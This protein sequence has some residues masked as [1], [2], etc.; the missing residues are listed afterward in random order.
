MWNRL[1]SLTYIFERFLINATHEKI[2]KTL[3]RGRNKYGE[4][5]TLAA[6]ITKVV[7]A[8]IAAITK[9]N[10]RRPGSI[11]PDMMTDEEKR[12][13]SEGQAF[14]AEEAAFK[15]LTADQRLRVLDDRQNTVLCPNCKSKLHKSD[16]KRDKTKTLPH[17]CWEFATICEDC[18]VRVTYRA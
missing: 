15:K 4:D 11:K 18:G 8:G 2:K 3:R 1:N 17:G 16:F 7:E 14:L 5:L 13:M 10:N 12:E 6:W 9:K